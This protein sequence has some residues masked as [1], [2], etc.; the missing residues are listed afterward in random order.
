[1]FLGT[2]THSLDSKSRLTIP[3]KYRDAVAAGLVITRH[4]HGKCLMAMP[5]SEWEK[6][7]AEVSKNKITDQDAAMFQRL[8]FS[9]AEDLVPDKQGRIL[10]GQRLREAAGIENDV[11]LAGINTYFE[12]WTPDEWEKTVEPLKDPDMM[13]KMFSALSI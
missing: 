8:V 5:L 7:A 9:S 6:V 3:A 12:L 13:V 2:Y 11:I 10:I 4:P 1:M